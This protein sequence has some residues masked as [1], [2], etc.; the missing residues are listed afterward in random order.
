M[1]NVEIKARHDKHKKMRSYLQSNNARFEGIDNQTDT[2]FNCPN[3]R[4]KLREGNI[5]NNLIFY[6]RDDTVRPKESDIQLH[7]VQQ[8]KTLKKVLTESYGVDIV[9]KKQREIYFIEN[10]KF[11]LDVI[12]SLGKFAEIEAIDQTGTIGED[13]LTNQCQFYM[14]ALQITP[15]MLVAE[16]YSD[17]LR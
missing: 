11:H 8:S 13:R 2:Y 9:V 4:L 1:K 10:V 5:E 16:S 15:D 6:R 12:E 3:G 17:M 14:E 7:P